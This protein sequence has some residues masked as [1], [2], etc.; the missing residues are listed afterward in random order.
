MSHDNSKGRDPCQPTD[1]DWHEV[2]CVECERMVMSE[3]AK[4]CWCIDCH[5][6]HLEAERDALLKVLG[7][8]DA[9]ID[10]DIGI[11]TDHAKH[12]A[13]GCA[14][15]LRSEK[16]V[17]KGYELREAYRAARAEISRT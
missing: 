11:C 6:A 7:T 12:R 10:H 13:A 3:D 5:L 15:C 9:A 8:A 4:P 1:G 14:N 2:E 16:S 17:R